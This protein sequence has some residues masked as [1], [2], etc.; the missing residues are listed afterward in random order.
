[1]TNHSLQV[2][3]AENDFDF[4]ELQDEPELRSIDLEYFQPVRPFNDLHISDRQAI[5]Q[6]SDKGV[7]SAFSF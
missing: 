5:I 7:K 4:L 1:M 2:C 3:L 6:G